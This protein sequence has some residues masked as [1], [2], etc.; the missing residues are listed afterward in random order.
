M[1]IAF[2]LFPFYMV[3]ISHKPDG[4]FGL[5]ELR[6]FIGMAALQ[7][8]AQISIG[9]YILKNRVPQYVILSAVCMALSFQAT[10]GIS[11]VLL[12]NT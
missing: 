9:W 6:H 1:F 12:A 3:Y 11:V 2:S 5:W 10:F 7:A 8:A 4:E